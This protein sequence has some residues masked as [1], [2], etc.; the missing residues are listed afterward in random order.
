VHE[1]LRHLEAAG[2]A[3]SP[4]VL[5]VEGDFEILTYLEGQVAADPNWH[6]GHEHQLP[7]FAKTSQALQAAARLL[8]ELHESVTGFVPTHTGYRFHP[9]P[10]LPDQIIGHGDL[11]PW[12]TVYRAGL[13]VAFIDFDSAGPVRP[14]TDLASAAW[15]FVP[16]APWAT[17]ISGR[18][19]EFVTAY[20]LDDPAAILPELARCR[21]PSPAM[22]EQ[23]A[24]DGPG[25][26]DKLEYTAGE[27]RWI[28]SVMPELARA[29][30]YE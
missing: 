16:L 14:L 29:L 27:L 22:I 28:Q 5:G 26:A 3:G 7:A 1:Y 9:H 12:N 11:G 30:R 8:R 21:L 25:M 6:P 10:P 19:A 15:S 20:G 17:D 2:F 23:V 18:L 13:P 24:P 4:R